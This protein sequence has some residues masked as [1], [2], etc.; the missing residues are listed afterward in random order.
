MI[1]RLTRRALCALAFLAMHATPARGQS[2]AARTATVKSGLVRFHFAARPGICGDGQHF[3]R[4][5]RSY[6][7]NNFGNMRDLSCVP[8]PVQV[9]LTMREGA[10]E[11]LEYWVGPLRERDGQ[12]LGPISSA[13]AARFLMSVATLASGSPSARAILPAVLAD[14]AIVWPALVTIA[15]D[16]DTRSQATRQEAMLWLSRFA[17]GA[18]VGRHSDPTVGED[19]DDDR[20]K[21]GDLKTHAVFVLS[22]LRNR[23]GVPAL[24]DIAR[25]NPD[26]HVRSQA[27][28]WL[29]QSGDPRALNL[30]ESILRS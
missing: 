24:L 23:E 21:G 9:R 10:V 16:T 12:S 20:S 11:R 4:M 26:R 14:S 29:G 5:G 13:E 18:L 27:L 17:A 1:M 28:F 7:G 25:S 3:I 8:G 6:I 15:R 30:F 22:Q 2:L 19:D